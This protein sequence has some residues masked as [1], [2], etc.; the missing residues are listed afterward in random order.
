MEHTEIAV[1]ALKYPL[2]RD[3]LQQTI[4]GFIAYLI[5]KPPNHSLSS[6]EMRCYMG[7]DDLTSSHLTIVQNSMTTFAREADAFIATRA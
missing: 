4:L 2:R 1:I 5:T 3:E 7:F 6:I